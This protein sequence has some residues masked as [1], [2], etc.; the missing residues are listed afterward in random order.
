M[1][2]GLLA[3][4]PKEVETAILK[5]TGDWK[6]AL[7]VEAISSGLINRFDD[8]DTAVKSEGKKLAVSVD[9]IKSKVVKAKVLIN[10]AF[11]LWGSLHPDFDLASNVKNVRAL[12]AALNP[13]VKVLRYIHQISPRSLDVYDVGNGAVLN[14][15]MESIKFLHESKSKGLGSGGTAAV[16]AGNFEIVKWFQA[17]YQKGFSSWSFN[18][19]DEEWS[20]L[21]DMEA[22]PQGGPVAHAASKGNLD[23]VKYLHHS[24]DQIAMSAAAARGHVDVMKWLHEEKKIG[25]T[26]STMELAATAG[27]LE[28]VKFIAKVMPQGKPHRNV[29][30]STCRNGHLDVLKWLYENTLNEFNHHLCDDFKMAMEHK[31]LGIIRFLLDDYQKNGIR[32]S[33][34][35]QRVLRS[36]DYDR[37]GEL[38]DNA[39]D[40]LK[41]TKEVE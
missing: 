6:T 24:A 34:H 14:G 16:A 25:C 36:F 8:I 2:L 35:Y 13:T 3:R 18:L 11:D 5:L 19:C 21:I 9:L 33:Y 39:G 10:Q 7:T 31:H 1:P 20:Y 15:E 29:T 4:L 38:M 12:L 40:M 26:D 27:H 41:Y 22:F 28:A 32:S 30:V 23:L 17:N 37:L